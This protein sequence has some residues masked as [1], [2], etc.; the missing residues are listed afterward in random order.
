[1]TP[2]DF[3]TDCAD[4][5]NRPSGETIEAMKKSIAIFSEGEEWTVLSYYYNE[6]TGRMTLDI[7]R[8]EE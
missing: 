3:L 8:K 4:E 5:Y 7:E 6:D 1:M 2:L